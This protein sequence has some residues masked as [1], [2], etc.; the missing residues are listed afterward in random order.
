MTSYKWRKGFRPAVVVICAALAASSAL[1]SPAFAEDESWKDDDD[2]MSGPGVLTGKEGGF[3]ISVWRDGEVTYSSKPPTSGGSG[4]PVDPYAALR[5]TNRPLG[6]GNQGGYVPPQPQYGYPQQGQPYGQQ[7]YQQPYQQQGYQQP[8]QQQPYRQHYP[9]QPMVQPRYPAYPPPAPAPVRKKAK[10]GGGSGGGSGGGVSQ[11]YPP[12][13]P[14]YGQPS[15]PYYGP[16]Q[17]SGEMPPGY[18]RP[19]SPAYGGQQA[20]R[21]GPRGPVQLNNRTGAGSAN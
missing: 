7:P 9:A 2:T 10:Q 15:P 3:A 16:A 21:P 4:A 5:P 12:P 19:A 17:S 20:Y 8:Y 6:T 18:Y 11:A 14:A 13:M 1:F